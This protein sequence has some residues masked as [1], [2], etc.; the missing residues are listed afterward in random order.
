MQQEVLPLP[1]APKM[2]I[3]VNNPRSGMVSQKG[4][5]AGTGLRGL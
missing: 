2:A 3:P 4:A 5:L 1:M